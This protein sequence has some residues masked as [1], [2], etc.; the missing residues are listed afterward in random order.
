MVAVTADAQNDPGAHVALRAGHEVGYRFPEGFHG[1]SGTV[2]VSTCMPDGAVEQDHGSVTVGGAHATEV[3]GFTSGD[4]AD[5][6][7]G[8]LRSMAGH[9]WPTPYAEADGKHTLTLRAEPGNPLG[10][11]IKVHDDRFDSA[12]RVQNDRISQVIRTM[13]PMTFTITI[14]Q[15]QTVPDGR[16]LPEHFTVNNWKE[17]RLAR[18]DMY[19]DVYR[20][21]DGVWTPAMRRVV[22]AADDGFTTRQLEVTDVSLLTEPVAVD[23]HTQ[24]RTGT[25]AG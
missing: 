15:H 23:E 3:D 17:G 4:I 6:A 25:R 10:D 12:Y 19:K 20:E 18:T 5:W 8:E 14:Q 11:Y 9:R 24:E 13:G 1:F 16:V 7:K 21:T 2:H 22:T